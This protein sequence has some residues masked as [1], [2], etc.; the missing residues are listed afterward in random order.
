MNQIRSKLSIIPQQP[1]LFKESLRYN[2]DPLNQYSDEECWL[3]LEDVQLRSYVKN[4]PDGLS[5]Q[6]TES[7]GNLSV[8]QSQLLCIARALLRK[9]K[10]L[11]I[12]EATANVNKEMDNL[13]QRVISDKFRDRT[14]LII[15][16]RLETVS[17]C[18]LILQLDKGQL[19]SY[20]TLDDVQFAQN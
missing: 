6:L 16:H 19:T 3:V 17:N 13:I 20:N 12:D 9:S 7:G 14:I 15:A 2:L 1:F 18:D 11:L 4:H 10:I 8:G 5:M